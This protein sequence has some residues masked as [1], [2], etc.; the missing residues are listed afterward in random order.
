MGQRQWRGQDYQAH[1]PLGMKTDERRCELFHS[2]NLQQPQID[3]ERGA[4]ALHFPQNVRQCVNRRVVVGQEPQHDGVP[5][6]RSLA[7]PRGDHPRRAARRL[8]NLAGISFAVTERMPLPLLGFVVVLVEDDPDALALFRVMLEYQGA[9]VMSAPGAQAALDLLGRMKPDVLVSDMT[10][11]EWDGAWLATEARNRG[12]L[13]SVATLVVTAVA[14]TPQQVR[15]AG[16]DAYLRKPV[17]PH[18]LCQTVQVL[19]RPGTYP[20]A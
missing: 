2:R 5:G 8:A 10:M 14:M 13:K 7:R 11:P 9:L 16:F 20:S 4:A 3:A 15:E 17:D 18:L 12:L 1:V 6:G 19:A